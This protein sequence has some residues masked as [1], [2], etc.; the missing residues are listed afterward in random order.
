MHAGSNGTNKED[1]AMPKMVAVPFKTP[2]PQAGKGKKR[3]PAAQGK[4]GSKPSVLDSTAAGGK[5]AAAAS[6]AHTAQ[7][8]LPS[9]PIPGSEQTGGKLH[10]SHEPKLF[11]RTSVLIAAENVCHCYYILHAG[12]H[13]ADAMLFLAACSL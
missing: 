12:A 6:V 9:K 13:L 11:F 1:A 5:A 4:Q 7:S 10:N 8:D 3:N 2:V